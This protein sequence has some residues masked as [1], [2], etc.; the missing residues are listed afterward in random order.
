MFEKDYDTGHNILYNDTETREFHWLVTGKQPVAGK[1]TDSRSL[2]FVAHRCLGSG[3]FDK[4]VVIKE[5][6]EEP[7]F[8]SKSTCFSPLN[9]KEAP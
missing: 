1:I 8:W 6:T 3:C 5:I 4:V 7:R 9:D 2:K